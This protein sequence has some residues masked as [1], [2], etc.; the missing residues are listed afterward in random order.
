MDQNAM[1]SESADVNSLPPAV[2]PAVEYDLEKAAAFKAN[3]ESQQ[4][5]PLAMIAGFVAAL[6]G[7]ALWAAV[8]VATKYQIGWLAVGVGFL[9]GI[10]VRKAGRGLTKPFGIVGAIC[11]LFGC[12]LGNLLSVCGFL[13]TEESMPFVQVLFSVLVH[14]RIAAEIMVATF[15]PMDLLFYGIAIY[16]GYKFSFR[17]ITA[18][19]LASLTK[20]APAAV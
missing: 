15:S 10:A 19:E 2:P 5:L 13:A 14:P 4:N 6:I 12:A 7:A 11:A 20:P 3:L 16:E 18:E 8:T 17:E 9:V 1:P